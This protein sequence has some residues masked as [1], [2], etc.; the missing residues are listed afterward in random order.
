MK[1][2]GY[3]E[4]RPAA[5][6][7]ASGSEALNNLLKTCP[8]DCWINLVNQLRDVGSFIRYRIF[9]PKAAEQGKVVSHAVDLP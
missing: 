3:E 6:Q 9:K 7:D 2:F 1:R 4:Q 8:T 5:L